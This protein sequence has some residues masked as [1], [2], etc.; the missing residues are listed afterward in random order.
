MK[1]TLDTQPGRMSRTE[2]AMSFPSR[3]CTFAHRGESLLSESQRSPHESTHAG[4]SNRSAGA[5]QGE[6]CPVSGTIYVVS[7][8]GDVSVSMQKDP[9]VSGTEMTHAQRIL[10][11]ESVKSRHMV[12]AR[13]IVMYGFLIA[14]V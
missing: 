7:D 5:N 4:G 12:L 8:T 3:R 9:I 2:N 1:Y 6:L 13:S 10:T 11:Q 14:L